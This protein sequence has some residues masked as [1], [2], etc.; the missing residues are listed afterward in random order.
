MPYFH[1]HCILFVT[2]HI[3]LVQELELEVMVCITHISIDILLCIDDLE[4]YMEVITLF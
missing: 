3:S 1:V 4:K 2:K